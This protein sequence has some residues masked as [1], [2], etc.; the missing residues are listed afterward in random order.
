MRKTLKT[1]LLSSIVL[2]S[3]SYAYES[4]KGKIDMHGGKEDSLTKGTA[5]N[6]AIGIGSVL[7][8]KGSSKEEKRA[9]K[10]FISLEN[11]ETIQKIEPINK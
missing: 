3:A 8:K 11:K 4:Q 5:F 6:M 7:N 9:D 10:K 2:T 1:L